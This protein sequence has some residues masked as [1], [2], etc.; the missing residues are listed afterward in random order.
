MEEVVIKGR[1]ETGAVVELS[2]KQRSGGSSAVAVVAEQSGLVYG[3]TIQKALAGGQHQNI[4]VTAGGQYE[5]NS[6]IDLYFKASSVASDYGLIGNTDAIGAEIARGAGSLDTMT[7]LD[8]GTGDFAFEG[9][10]KIDGR[11]A[12]GIGSLFVAGRQLETLLPYID[13]KF[14][15]NASNNTLDWGLTLASDSASTAALINTTVNV[16]SVTIGELMHFFINIDRQGAGNDVVCT[17]YI[18]GT[19]VSTLTGVAADDAGAIDISGS[20][21]VSSKLQIGVNW[22]N[23]PSWVGDIY[24]L[25]FYTDALTDAQITTRNIAGPS[26]RANDAGD[27]NLSW[28]VDFQ[29]WAT[30]ADINEVETTSDKGNAVFN[31]DV[32]LIGSVGDYIAVKDDGEPALPSESVPIFAGGA[33]LIAIPAGHLWLNLYS[34]PGAA[35]DVNITKIGA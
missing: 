21:H 4:A 8:F 7:G 13:F 23:S 9:W 17:L 31:A 18:N 12:A 3:E 26:A 29:N 32:A 11:P 20:T 25:R 14:L 6:P 27:V 24:D 1:D 15:K 33:K 16:P 28:E 19:P 10:F 35:G 22:N 2:L 34:K 5:I 30:W